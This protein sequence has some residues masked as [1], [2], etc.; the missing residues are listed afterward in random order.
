MPRGGLSSDPEKRERQLAALE[1]GRLVATD[2]RAKGLPTK[3]RES[4]EP[5]GG[6]RQNG[7]AG[8]PADDD[9]GT[10][11]VRGGYEGGTGGRSREQR[12]PASAEDDG[13]GGADEDAG[14]GGP[15]L[16]WIERVYGRVLGYDC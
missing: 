4:R 10:R 9:A 1:H 7:T 2:R 11:I 12:R 15:E 6:H 3:R 8:D 13:A 16:G 5:P 14:A